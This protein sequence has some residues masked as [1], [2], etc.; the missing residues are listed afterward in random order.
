MTKN[1]SC[2]VKQSVYFCVIKVNGQVEIRRSAC[3]KQEK[4]WHT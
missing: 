2:F 3:H 1:F 4:I